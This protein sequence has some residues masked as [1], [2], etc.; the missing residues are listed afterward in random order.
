MA[1]IKCPECGRENVSDKAEM[2]PDCGYGIKAHFEMIEVE[3]EQRRLEQA[4]KLEND[5]R[6]QQ[7]QE[8]AKKE[9]ERKQ[10]E[11]EEMPAPSK[12]FPWMIILG[13]F[14]AGLAIVMFCIPS[15][16]LG[17]FEA[18]LAFVLIVGGNE[19]YK[20]KKRI[21]ELSLKDLNSAKRQAQA[22][23]QYSEAMASEMNSKIV[24]AVNPFKEVSNGVKCPM[25][26]KNS[27]KK[28]T[29]TS[30]AASVAMVGLASGKIGK[31]YKCTSCGHMW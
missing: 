11:L 23:Q 4:R 1:L 31:Q 20:E 12:P 24:N 10:K 19:D 15:I 13:L 6:Y 9:E 14:F 30:R 3:K 18:F 22:Y 16:L 17:L 29:T 2:C 28:I 8:E 26:G 25:C 27:G 7:M 5:M 21:Y